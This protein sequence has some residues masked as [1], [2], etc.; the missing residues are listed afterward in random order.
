M[1]TNDNNHDTPKKVGTRIMMNEDNQI[2]ASMTKIILVGLT[3]KYTFNTI[4]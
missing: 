1:S 2:F 4:R 3:D